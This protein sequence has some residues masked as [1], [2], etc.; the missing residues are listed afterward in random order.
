VSTSAVRGEQLGVQVTPWASAADIVHTGQTLRHQVD[1]VF[2]QDQM[3]AR[4]VYTMLGAL[5]VHGCG[6]GTNVTWPFGRNPIEMASSAATLSELVPAGRHVTIGI[7]SGGALAAALVDLTGRAAVV[8]EAIVLM[9]GLWEGQTVELDH[10]P[11]LGRRLGFVP[12]AQATLTY[13]VPS[14]PRLLVAGVGPRI[15]QVAARHAD[16]VIAA[17]NLPMY[18]GA[19][20][21]SGLYDEL[22][23][24]ASLRARAATDQSFRMH[25]GMNVSVARDRAAARSHARRQAALIVGNPGMWAA[26]ERL[27]FDM[28][29]VHAVKASIDAGHGVA[30]AASKV[31]ESLADAL[32]VSGTVDDVVEPL[33]QLRRLAIDHG[34]TDF[35]LGGPLGPD[36]VEAAE[37]LSTGVIPAVWPDRCAA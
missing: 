19:S 35:F 26:M 11:H 1:T 36:H 32:I 8:E 23:D 10:F 7:G 6:V 17:S 3:L 20:M 9:K 21:R 29:S 15:T 22:V 14:R 31:S 34:Y 30:G 33:A 27:D 37:L 5:A 24:G 2:L 4:N 25:Y 16:G 28:A 18:S 12:G 13:A